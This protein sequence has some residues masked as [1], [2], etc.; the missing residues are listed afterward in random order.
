MVGRPGSEKGR[1][2]VATRRIKTGELVLAEEPLLKARW[3]TRGGERTAELE[4]I[5]R[6]LK[7]EEAQLVNELH[8]FPVAGRERCHRLEHILLSNGYPVSDDPEHGEQGI[9]PVYSWMSFSCAPNAHHFW[10]KDFGIL[11]VHATRDIEEGEVLTVSRLYNA[12]PDLCRACRRPYIKLWYGLDDCGC[13]LCHMSPAATA[14]SDAR[15]E[16]SG[17]M[18]NAIL[19]TTD[20]WE[21]SE[22]VSAEKCRDWRT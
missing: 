17:K 21:S 15:R 10:Q 2:L 11:L 19:A 5:M 7:P 3:P 16:Q 20:P 13:S 8:I 1:V 12:Q 6:G 9:F 4:R 22:M 18:L 14:T